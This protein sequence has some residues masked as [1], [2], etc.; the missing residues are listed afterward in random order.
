MYLW[1][2]NIIV[3]NKV[4]RCTLTE[5]RHHDH[6]RSPT[7]TY[8]GH[9][10]PIQSQQIYFLQ[11]FMIFA[12]FTIFSH[13]QE[14]CW[15]NDDNSNLKSFVVVANAL[16]TRDIWNC[17]KYDWIRAPY[18]TYQWWVLAWWRS[19]ELWWKLC[20]LYWFGWL[21]VSGMVWWSSVSPWCCGWCCSGWLYWRWMWTPHPWL[22]SPQ[23]VYWSVSMLMVYQGVT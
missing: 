15:Y 23:A 2:N 13:F 12:F 21:M 4:K 1:Y 3:N 14:K 16:W 7:M 20:S 11:T 5:L 10:V 6:F 9:Q 18:V 19:R 17:E 8:L 22:L